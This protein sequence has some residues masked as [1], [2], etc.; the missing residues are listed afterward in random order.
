[1]KNRYAVK[2]AI[3]NPTTIFNSRN[4]SA[5][6]G[7]STSVMMTRIAVGADGGT[8]PAAIGGGGTIA[9]GRFVG[10]GFMVGGGG[11]AGGGGKGAPQSHRVAQSGCTS[12][13]FGQ[14]IVIAAP[15]L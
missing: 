4:V 11:W 15:S 14:S 3:A 12:P 13:H 5:P 8:L 1:M 2:Y 9:G 6:S 10:G 7:M